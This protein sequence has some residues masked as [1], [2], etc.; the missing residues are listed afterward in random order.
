MVGGAEAAPDAGRPPRTS[1]L[2]FVPYC[3]E[4]AGAVIVRVTA[5]GSNRI[6]RLSAVS[7]RIAGRGD[8][9]GVAAHFRSVWCAFA[10]NFAGD[11]RRE[12]V[13]AP[14]RPVSIADTGTE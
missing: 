3:Y 7:V 12:S 4:M 10:Q 11:G 13:S 14:T 1:N 8:E 2:R 6:G 5:P 9:V